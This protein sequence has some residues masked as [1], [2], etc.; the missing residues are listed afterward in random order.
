MSLTVRLIPKLGDPH[1][2]LLPGLRERGEVV[3]DS[4]QDEDEF[5]IGRGGHTGINDITVEDEAFR[6]SFDSTCFEEH[7]V[8][9]SL[10]KESNLY[11]NG[12]PW[13]AVQPHVYLSH[14]DVVSLD[15]LR[16][17][18]KIHIEAR[19]LPRASNDPPCVKKPKL[20]SDGVADEKEEDDS[21]SSLKGK[22]KPTSVISIPSDS[23]SRLAEEIQC[24]VCLDIQV[25][26]RTLYPCGHSFCCACLQQ[27]DQCP[28]CRNN[29]E[30]HVPA[31]QLDS[32]ISALVALPNLL[33]K[34]DVDHYFA[35]KL[36]IPRTVRGLKDV[37]ISISLLNLT[38]KFETA[39]KQSKVTPKSLKCKRRIPPAPGP[40]S[41]IPFHPPHHP[42]VP[43]PS[44]DFWSEPITVS[45][46]IPPPQGPAV[47][48]RSVQRHRNRA[49]ATQEDA[50]SI[51]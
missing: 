1:E 26:P 28:Q 43:S 36:S 5:I 16:Y 15:G 12:F 39:T 13:D 45:Y 6:L 27:L 18:Y 50:I 9:A 21:S 34:G 32:L 42:V 49:G 48:S 38:L 10:L 33:D 29:I 14:G 37:A 4:D 47:A 25:H 8:R 51:D 19:G 3:F 7:Q 35:R 31:V 22:T 20:V 41:R 24:S 2:I 44:A 46:V 30:S 40:Q 23:A 17:E 11:L